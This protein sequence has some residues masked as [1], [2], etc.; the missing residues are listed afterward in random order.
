MGFHGYTE[1]MLIWGQGLMSQRNPRCPGH[2]WYVSHFTEPQ[3]QPHSGLL[4]DK[5]LGQSQSQQIG[6]SI[7][8]WGCAPSSKV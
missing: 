1:L 8:T 3:S 5:W 2:P 4:A 6:G 7:Q